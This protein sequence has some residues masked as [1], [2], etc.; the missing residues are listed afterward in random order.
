MNSWVTLDSWV[1]LYS[2][3]VL[4]I[5]NMMKE[6]SIYNTVGSSESFI[7]LCMLQMQA[8]CQGT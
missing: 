2:I 6:M 5:Q 3:I 4:D 7:K 8:I 1:I